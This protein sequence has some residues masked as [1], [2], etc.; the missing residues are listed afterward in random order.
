MPKPRIESSVE[1]LISK[2]LIE[3]RKEHNLS[4]R[5]LSHKLKLARY[6]MKKN[7]ITRL[8]TIKRYVTDIELCALAQIF[9][10][11][12]I[13]NVAFSLPVSSL[14]HLYIFQYMINFLSPFLIVARDN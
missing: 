7:V 12:S 2:R 4:Q 14:I 3:L 6:D 10:I 13:V 9:D 5:I 11:F 1:N 8:E